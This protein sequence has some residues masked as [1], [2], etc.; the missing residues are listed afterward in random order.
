VA[1]GEKDTRL[2]MTVRADLNPFIKGMVEK[3]MREVV[4]KI[5]DALVQLPYDR[6]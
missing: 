5:S 6:L 1:K 2:R 3:P 4:D